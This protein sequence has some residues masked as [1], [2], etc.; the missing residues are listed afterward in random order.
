M[1][2][3]PI[4]IVEDDEDDREIYAEAIKE[5]GITNELI[6]FENGQKALEYLSET[7]DQPFIIISDINMP[8][9]NGLELKKQ[10]QDDSYLSAKGIPFVFISTNSSN[11]SVRHA[12]ALSVQ[13]FFQ[14]PLNIT[15]WNLALRTL[16]NYWGLC[17]H[18][19]N[20]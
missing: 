7:E 3:G 4:V 6:F 20:T 18:I 17:K 19:N 13:G 15:D 11:V 8:V 5:L 10:I 16:F 14:K 2:K 12:H 1:T 9:M